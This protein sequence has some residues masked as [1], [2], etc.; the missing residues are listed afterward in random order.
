MAE[1]TY[2]WGYGT[3]PWGSSGRKTKAEILVS[4]AFD[5][6]APEHMR[7]MFSIADAI[8]DAGSD[9]GFGGGDREFAEQDAEFRRRHFIAPS[10][11]WFYDGHWWQRYSWAAAYAPPG[12]SWHEAG[13]SVDGALAVDALG[14]HEAATLLCDSR[15]L[16]NHISGEAWHYQPREIPHARLRDQVWGKLGIFPLPDSPPPP[17]PDPGDDDMTPLLKPERAYDS[18][19]GEQADVDPVLGTANQAV[20]KTPFKAG[21]VR[22]IVIGYTSQAFV[23]IVAIGSNPGYVEVS[24][25][26]ARPTTSL[27][28]IDADGIIS[29]T[30]PVLTPE[31][32]VYV[33]ASAPCDVIV[34]VRARK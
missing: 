26:A 12:N 14:D 17:P 24:G 18:R 30:T 32:K 19:P 21:E 22:G 1:R 23:S 34:D 27:C 7:R 2:L 16:V 28:N 10:G 25:S 11:I 8:I 29:G 4:R 9:F 5:H 13:A 33:Y 6:V 20:P 15:G 31:G 3:G